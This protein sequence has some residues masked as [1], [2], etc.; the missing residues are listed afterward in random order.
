MSQIPGP[1]DSNL[2]RLRARPPNRDPRY[3][4]PQYRCS[5]SS[6]SISSFG[7]P[8]YIPPTH[9]QQSNNDSSPNH[10][11]A[12]SNFL[13]NETTNNSIHVMS[14]ASGTRSNRRRNTTRS[15]TSQL[16]GLGS[17]Q[18][19]N[20]TMS[21]T[22][23]SSGRMRW[24]KQMNTDLLSA[25]YMATKLE[26]KKSSYMNE[27]RTIWNEKYRNIEMNNSR[28]NSQINSILRR[29]VF[30]RVEINQIK[31]QI[32]RELTLNTDEV[33]E[34]VEN[35]IDENI[36]NEQPMNEQEINSIAQ[37]QNET[38]LD[39]NSNTSIESGNNK[40]EIM[41][42]FLDMKEK[43]ANVE[44][45][46]KPKIPTVPNN[47]KA[48]IA[49]GNVNE[50]LKQEFNKSENIQ[51]THN[52]IYCAALTV[53]FLMNISMIDKSSKN[54]KPKHT[55]PPWKFR[56]ETK[57]T[58]LRKDIGILTQY[59]TNPNNSQKV[60][61]KVKQ[62]CFRA[63]IKQWKCDFMNK[64]KIHLE[65]LK[66]NVAALGY[67]LR[68]YNKRVKRY[69]Q[70]K[71]FYFNQ[72]RFYRDLTSKPIPKNKTPPSASNLYNFW[73]NIWGQ[74]INHKRETP[75]IQEE[76]QRMKN[77]PVMSSIQITEDD[78]CNAIKYTSNWKS[79][80]LDQ[81]QNY[82]LKHFTNIHPVLACQFQH[83]IQNPSELP[84]FLTK[85]ITYM[86]PKNEKIDNPASYRPVTCLSTMYKLLTSILKNKIYD[87]IQQHNI[88][89]KEQNGVRPQSNGC[90]ELLI[91]DTVISKQAK[92]KNK[93][94]SIAWIDYAKAYDSTPHSWLLEILQI[95]KIDESVIEF[96]KCAMT[97]WRTSLSLK[98]P[99]S[100]SDNHNDNNN[101]IRTEEIHLKNGIYQGDS[102]SSLWFCLALN[103]ISHQLNT[104][105][106]G[107]KLNKSEESRITH[108]FYMDDLKLYAQNESQLQNQ[109]EIVS[110]VSRDICMSFGLEKC[111]VLN[112]KRGRITHTNNIQ[113]SDNTELQ[114]LEN[115][116]TYKYLG[117]QQ[118]LN[119]NESE[120]KDQ[121]IQK[122]IKRVKIIMNTELYCRNKIQAIN[123]WAVPTITYTFAIINWTKTDLQKINRK[124]R[125]IMTQYRS[126]HPKSAVERLYL[127]RHMGGRGLIDLEAHHAKE[128]DRLQRYFTK[129][130]SPFHV[131]LKSEDNYTPLK[132][133]NGT[134]TTMQYNNIE[135]LKKNW[136]SGAMKG[137]YPKNL[138]DENVDQT[139][140]TRY[141]KKSNIFSETIGFMHAIQDKTIKTKNYMKYIMKQNVNDMCRLCGKITESIE[142]LSSGCSVLAPKEY[143]NRHNL[144]ANVIHQALK[145]KIQA[146]T[147]SV[148]YYKYN[149]QPV[150]ENNDTKLYWNMPIITDTNIQHNRP[151]IVMMDKETS[152]L[153]N[154][155]KGFII[156]VAIPLDENMQKTYIEKIRKYQDLKYKITQMYKLSSV[157][158]IPIVISS[159]G[160][161]HK[162]TKQGLQACGLNNAEHLIEICQKSVIL[163]TTSIIRKCLNM[164]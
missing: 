98:L 101:E 21:N 9:T 158:V 107:Y 20:P 74:Q 31:D 73:N 38:Q 138:E 3:W 93:N 16:S 110:S 88:L 71:Q 160:L 125:T 50:C 135:T 132:L 55:Q 33:D 95:Y 22:S 18:N 145:N 23:R 61:K 155:G 67:K 162:N 144:V 141:L 56:L 91:I 89:C 109:L 17:S 82:W 76:I 72:R 163:S 46:D 47:I 104:H 126:H 2:F 159:N 42:H 78:V 35:E 157:S 85:G 148:P 92:I 10:T 40:E 52:I 69:Q 136:K 11:L 149:P 116:Q 41:K 131:Q 53:C 60:K 84:K 1:S 13:P 49:V 30:S 153:N 118:N 99:N 34:I 25:Y 65:N 150:V 29:N 24:T 62:L 45:K 39:P 8:G 15:T 128:V 112:I 154:N 161:V 48:K 115:D 105:P 83:C 58:K 117:M 114:S 120:S 75:W 111:K 57:I 103:P 36:Q 12:E 124:V 70:N 164:T 106:Y 140:S 113:L 14:E 137:K 97:S 134:H 86:L 64:L 7:S 127:P 90:K 151:D 87:H 51:E 146:S 77:V 28:L 133:S 43:Y 123:A 44:P 68:R 4:R 96:L 122:F 156:D 119:I 147:T 142:H 152:R 80:G 59:F 66:Q 5:S 129:K 54:S 121:F 79:P 102:L 108:S 94:I 81:I 143:T 27:V 63:R 26:T 130:N 139:M 32:S 19:S 100:S 37:E 6:S